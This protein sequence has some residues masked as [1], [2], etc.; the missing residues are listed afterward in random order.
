MQLKKLKLAVRLDFLLGFAYNSIR[1]S[2]GIGY[3]GPDLRRLL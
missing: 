3:R 1:F 2:A